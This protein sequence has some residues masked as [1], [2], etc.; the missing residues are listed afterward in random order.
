MVY[1][2]HFRVVLKPLAW[3]IFLSLKL[4]KGLVV[5]FQFWQVLVL[6]C[7]ILMLHKWSSWRIPLACW[8]LDALVLF[9]VYP[10]CKE[11][12]HKLPFVRKQHLLPLPLKIVL[13]HENTCVF[14]ILSCPKCKY[15]TIFLFLAR[16]L[17]KGVLC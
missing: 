9:K 3:K 14:L 10:S 6:N 2:K 15:V 12:T 5:L 1:S 7:E 11:G 8:N 16:L 13:L 17:G 4:F